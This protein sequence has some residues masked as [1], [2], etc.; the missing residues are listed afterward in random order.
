MIYFII[1]DY[2]GGCVVTAILFSM[3]EDSKFKIFYKSLLWPY[4]LIK[5]ILKK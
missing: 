2:I 3:F 4:Y 5:L 1:K